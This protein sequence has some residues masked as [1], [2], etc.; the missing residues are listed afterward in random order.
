MCSVEPCL[1]EPYVAECIGL[2]PRR[3]LS[4]KNVDFLLFQYVVRNFYNFAIANNGRHFETQ[5]TEKIS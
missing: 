4:Y 3:Q 2:Q 5:I 1:D